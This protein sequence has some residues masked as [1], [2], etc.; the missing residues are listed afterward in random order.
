MYTNVS[1]CVGLWHG[2]MTMMK[3]QLGKTDHNFPKSSTKTTHNFCLNIDTTSLSLF[4]H[5][6]SLSIFFDHSFSL[7]HNQI[8]QTTFFHLTDIVPPPH[9][10]PGPH[11]PCPSTQCKVLPMTLKTLH[12]LT[13]T[14]L[15]DQLHP[16]VTAMQDPAPE[17]GRQSFFHGCTSLW[18]PKKHL[19]LQRSLSIEDPPR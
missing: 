7:N 1:S 15:T 4:A 10:V 17:Q 8:P 6:R 5:I 9:S 2:D 11:R 12:N 14:Y 18:N 16:P 19:L 13:A 3:A